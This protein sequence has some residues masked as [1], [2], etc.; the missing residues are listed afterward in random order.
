[1]HRLPDTDADRETNVERQR[2]KERKTQTERDI[3]R[4][5]VRTG[6]TLH[7]IHAEAHS[8]SIVSGLTMKIRVRRLTAKVSQ[9]PPRRALWHWTHI[10]VTNRVLRKPGSG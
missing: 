9:I 5:N 3:A 8:V 4:T 6:R 7:R 2:Q 10:R 1:M